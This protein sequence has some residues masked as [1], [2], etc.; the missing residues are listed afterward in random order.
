M[1]KRM[2]LPDQLNEINTNMDH[3]D[4]QYS[5]N[6]SEPPVPDQ[7]GLDNAADV[8]VTTRHHL[9]CNCIIMKMKLN[10][11]NLSNQ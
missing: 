4:S 6:E 8:S 2:A 11:T 3:L 9:R 7:L 5:D 10:P 1:H